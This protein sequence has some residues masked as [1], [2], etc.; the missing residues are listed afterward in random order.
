MKAISHK[1]TKY[2]VLSILVFLAF[3]NFLAVHKIQ[4]FA[5]PT[6]ILSASNPINITLTS[7]QVLRIIAPA[8]SNVTLLS[9]VGGQYD[10]GLYATG[11]KNILLFTPLQDSNYSMI[12]NVSSGGQNYAL[13][14]KQGLPTDSW[15]KNV[16][17]SGDLILNV[18][19]SVVPPPTTQNSS[20]NPL[21]GFTGISLG[22]ITLDA[23]DVLVIFALFSVS[24][25]V[26]GMKYSHKMLY[27]GIFF[28][29]LIG[30]IVIGI[31]VVGL[32]VGAYIAGF[33]VIKSF[34][35]FRA[36]RRN[37]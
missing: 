23:T 9:V 4:A 29:S 2:F 22:G 19:V 28:L 37:P 36:R 11:G 33:A 21:F 8:S 18:V 17:G 5:H 20:W 6:S 13:F 16:T 31:L 1:T 25:I 27:G 24:L 35:G 7:T 15:S 26:L 30:M 34:F 3:T 10:I 12:L 32:I 14:S